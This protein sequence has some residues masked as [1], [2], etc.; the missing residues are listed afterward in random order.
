MSEEKVEDEALDTLFDGESEEAETEEVEVAEETTGDT[1]EENVEDKT[2]T[3]ETEDT[4]PPADEEKPDLEIQ[5]KAQIAKAQD[6]KG[7]RQKLKQENEQLRQQM[8]AQPKPEAP[9]PFAEPDKALQHATNELSNNFDAKL[10]NMSEFHAKRNHKDYDEKAEMFYEKLQHDDPSLAV[11]ARNAPDPCEF[12]Y[13]TAK[14]FTDMAEL[15][16]AGGVQALID[17][18]VAEERLKWESE[19]EG[20]KN[21]EVED[22]ITKSIPG[23]LSTKRAAGSN[24]RQLQTDDKPL[25]KLFG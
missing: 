25:N 8:A 1:E 7:K 5:L 10:F 6:E 2:E 14:N 22:A 9:D 23:S 3:K 15:N 16:E 13:E 11:K 17:K 18:K 21:K 19:N 4:A 24:K 20:V 12:I